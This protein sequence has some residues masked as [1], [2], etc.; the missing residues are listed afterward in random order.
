M[1]TFELKHQLS[2]AKVGDF[3][4]K[5]VWAFHQTLLEGTL[6]S[7]IDKCHPREKGLQGQDY[8]KLA[9]FGTSLFRQ[10]LNVYKFSDTLNLAIWFFH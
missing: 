8:C 3:L 9:V 7:P 1:S 5:K 6:I 2:L 10:Y 4:E